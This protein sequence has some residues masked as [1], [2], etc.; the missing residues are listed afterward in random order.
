MSHHTSIRSRVRAQHRRVSLLVIVLLGAGMIASGAWAAPSLQ[1]GTLRIGYLGIDGTDAANGAHLAIDQI[2]STGGVA[3]PDGNSYQFELVTL[4]ATPSVE[5]L[6][7]DV[8]GLTAQSPVAL[9]GPDEAA[10]LSPE[11]VQTLVSTGLPVLTGVTTD[12]LTDDDTANVLF[13]IRAPERVYSYA[14]ATYLVGDLGLTSFVL[15]QTDVAST[16]AL[17]DF[18]AVLSTAGIVPAGKVQLAS[19]TGLTDQGNNIV[20]LNP[21]AVVMWGP[22]EDA[23][24]LL[25]QLRGS[26]WKGQFAYRFA[27]Q[28]AESKI[29]PDNLADGVIGVT[30]WSYAY[31]GR[32]ARIFLHDYVTT[33]GKVPGPL[34]VAAYDAMWYLRS[35]VQAAGVD[36]AAIRAALIQ[37]GAQA[38]VA[39][40]LDAATFGNGDLIRMAMVYSL[41]PGGGATVVAVFNDT[42]RLQIETAG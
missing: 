36:P 42:R 17:L 3:A 31:P 32:S 25:S 30:S 37:S 21:E 28:A 6:P 41:G 19:A 40:T 12:T 33:F 18:E 13:R 23:A 14:L 27:E 16:E 9:L 20:A 24:A 7:G 34:S 29:L 2:N 4:A 5:S 15:V 10:V 22:F 26:G 39:G 8:T 1:T 35:V 11:N 38:L